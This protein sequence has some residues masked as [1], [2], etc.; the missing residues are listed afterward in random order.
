MCTRVQP[1]AQWRGK[2]PPMAKRSGEVKVSKDNSDRETR[3][4]QALRENLRRR[5]AQARESADPPP[6]EKTSPRDD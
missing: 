2:A 3:L 1:N 5:K 4:A 6:P